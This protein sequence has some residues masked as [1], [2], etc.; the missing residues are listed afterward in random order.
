MKNI[1]GEYAH[2]RIMK[3]VY[4]AVFSFA[5]TLTLV[6]ILPGGLHYVYAAPLEDCDLDG[7][8]DATG[9]PVPWPGYDE[10]KGDT[11]EGPGGGITPTKA[12]DSTPGKT[13]SSAP[14]N[15][16]SVTDGNSG[17]TTSGDTSGSAIGNTGGAAADN[18]G[19]TTP[20]KSGGASTGN[21][22]GAAAGNTGSS[23]AGKTSSASTGNP[24]GAAAG[25]TNNATTG[26]TSSAATGNAGSTTAGNTE[27]AATGNTS[28]ASG[29]NTGSTA[30]NTGSTTSDNTGSIEPG[31]T[32]SAAS[33]ST[34][35]VTADGAGSTA[36]DAA[37]SQENILQGA[38]E[39]AGGNSNLVD[40][41]NTNAPAVELESIVNTKGALEVTEATGSLIHAGSSV[42]ISGSGFA[43]NINDLEIEIQSEER[44]LGTVASSENGSFEAQ[45]DI[46]EDLEAG[47]HNIVVLYQ[48]NE[49]T[50]RQIEVG[51]KAADTFIQALSVGFTK[52][53]RGLL[54]G[55]LIL[56]GLT[57]LGAAALAV[58]A[59]IRSRRKKI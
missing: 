20:G 32:D 13:D 19:S 35:N 47:T 4:K 33:G 34:G 42:I 31:N 41:E 51:P 6:L 30:G 52:E 46:P 39:Q 37:G 11:P 12:P 23:T 48:G 50:R 1:P 54:P 21:T 57:V 59:I 58:N 44:Q 3:K 7:Y 36:S 55:L 9:V 14:D 53:N 25:N 15:T 24:G 27:N 56:A 38:N 26:K 2:R 45:I 16:G 49:I 8:D 22:G 10:T 18:A 29:G 5:L 28:S 17:G 43:G 40:T